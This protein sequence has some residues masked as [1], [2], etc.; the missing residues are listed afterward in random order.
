MRFH[1]P[2]D[3]VAERRDGEGADGGGEIDIGGTAERTLH[4]LGAFLPGGVPQPG[5]AAAARTGFLQCIPQRLLGLAFFAPDDQVGERVGLA[6]V[7]QV[8]LT[9]AILLVA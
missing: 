5:E 4:L 1:N 6:A 8:E 9:A 7:L 3:W 2:K